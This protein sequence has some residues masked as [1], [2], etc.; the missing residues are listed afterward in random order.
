MKN[1]QLAIVLAICAMLAGSTTAFAGTAEGKKKQNI[2]N[3]KQCECVK[4]GDYK[5]SVKKN[6]KKP[7]KKEISVKKKG[8]RKNF[9]A[10]RGFDQHNK[11]NNKKVIIIK[12]I[13]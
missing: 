7:D 1:T 4:K 10:K 5:K 9:T 6:Q 12:H 2:E 11:H 8:G 13:A 3:K